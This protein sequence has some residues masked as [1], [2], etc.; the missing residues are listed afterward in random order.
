MNLNLNYGL[1]VIIRYHC[2][3]INCKKYSILRGDVYSGKGYASV[4]AE[5]IMGTLHV[6]L[7][8]SIGHLDF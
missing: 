4:G 8:F 7:N 3:L 2:R 6:S 1:R 5:S